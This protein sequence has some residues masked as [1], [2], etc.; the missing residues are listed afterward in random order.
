MQLIPLKISKYYKLLFVIIVI[1]YY[2]IIN[3]LFIFS[4]QRIRQ[5]VCQVCRMLTCSSLTG[6][7]STVSAMQEEENITKHPKVRLVPSAQTI[8]VSQPVSQQTVFVQEA[9]VRKWVSSA[10]EGGRRKSK[11]SLLICCFFGCVF[12]FFPNMF[13]ARVL[14]LSGIDELSELRWPRMQIG[15]RAQESLLWLIGIQHQASG[16][17]HNVNTSGD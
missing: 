9:P 14:P 8:K 6:D 17:Q 7:F 11:T 16:S 10:V 4:T 1:Y 12:V 13:C 15:V 3:Y 5:Q 2:I